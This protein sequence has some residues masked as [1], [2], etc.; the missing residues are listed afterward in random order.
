MAESLECAVLEALLH[1]QNEH[2]RKLLSELLPSELVQLNT[3]GGIMQI[4][5]GQIQDQ[6][7][8]NIARNMRNGSVS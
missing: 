8:L 7:A 2:A 1:H 5:I 6:R 4:M 3:A